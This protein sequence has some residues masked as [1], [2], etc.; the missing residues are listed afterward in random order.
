[1]VDLIV[2]EISLRR[3]I[4]VKFDLCPRPLFRSLQGTSDNVPASTPPR[5]GR[6][7]QV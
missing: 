4:V 3:E 5:A 1:M 2:S 7:E 6:E